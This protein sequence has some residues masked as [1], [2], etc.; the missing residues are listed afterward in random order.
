MPD[1]REEKR[2][3]GEGEEEE[4]RRYIL[5][6]KRQLLFSEFLCVFLETEQ[7]KSSIVDLDLSSYH[8]AISGLF[9]HSEKLL[10]HYRLLENG[11]KMRKYVLSNQL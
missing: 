10:C 5:Q 8:I 3:R 7:K 2:R 6:V 4:R 9:P 11:I 1:M